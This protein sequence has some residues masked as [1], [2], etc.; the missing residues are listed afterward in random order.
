MFGLAIAGMFAP[1]TASTAEI[2]A[3]HGDTGK[4]VTVTVRSVFAEPTYDFTRRQPELSGRPGLAGYRLMGL[5]EIEKTSRVSVGIRYRQPKNRDGICYGL[6]DIRV[7]LIA[8]PV[9]VYVASEYRKGTCPFKVTLKHENKHVA[10]E[11]TALAEH[12]ADLRQRLH[13]TE[14]FGWRHATS[15]DGA[16]RDAHQ[17]VQAI[18]SATLRSLQ[19][20]AGWRHARL[21]SPS[22][23]QREHALCGNAPA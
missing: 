23:Y 2:A 16:V 9:R 22:N 1:A 5:T 6:A 12:A 18:V 14:R 15:P 20:E 7:T 13:R 10:I 17:W 21:D 19:T 4:A 11:R 3:C 8:E